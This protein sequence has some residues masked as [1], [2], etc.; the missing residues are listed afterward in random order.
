M[1]AFQ[2]VFD[3]FALDISMT[4]QA[5]RARDNFRQ[6]T[7]D[8]LQLIELLFQDPDMNNDGRADLNLDKL[9]YYRLSLGHYGVKYSVLNQG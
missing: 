9:G 2:V 6:S 1:A 3:F 5:L 4:L 8:K 7:Y